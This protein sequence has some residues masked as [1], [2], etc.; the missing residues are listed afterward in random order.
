[1]GMAASQA[2]LL[3][4]TARMH[5][6]EYKAQSIQ[7]AKIQLATQ[8]DEVY[9]NY[10]AAL[11]A[12]T[13][14]IKDW[15]GNLIPATFNNICGENAVDIATGNKYAFRDSR[16]ALI[17]DGQIKDGY[18]RFKASGKDCIKG[19]NAAYMFAFYMMG[20]DVTDSSIF[21]TVKDS[22]KSVS[23]K[24]NDKTNQEAIDNIMKSARNAYVAKYGDLPSTTYENAYGPE[25]ILNAYRE[26]YVTV[27][28]V[29]GKIT[30]IKDQEMYELMEGYRKQLQDLLKPSLNTVYKAH[31]DEI[32]NGVKN[33][34]IG[35]QDFN[36]SKFDYYVRMYKE[37]EAAGGNCTSIQDYDS[38]IA[39]YQENGTRAAND[40]D[41]LQNMIKCGKITV[42]MV[43][44]DSKT[45]E[46]S[47]AS[48]S[49]PSDS[50]LEYTTTTTID[51]SAMAKAEAEYEHKNKEI[52]N[53][54]KR[55]DM[56]LSKLETERSALKT[57]YDS[58]KKIIDD[59][60]EKT[61]GIFS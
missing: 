32:Y 18:E 39:D 10:L 40:S 49:V 12:S 50:V 23:D 42:D 20:I 8:Q 3:T 17:V 29:T 56:D 54:D 36:Q 55:F 33:R 30:G 13:L 2:R 60:I 11:D 45:G 5:D 51:K 27:D 52:N 47:F 35:A 9:Q 21:G 43:K 7:E 4:I 22:Q 28:S 46:V 48:T 61:F 1:M 6:I 14:T 53:K 58:I 19:A 31:A 41:W 44:V 59:N 25:D 24:Y 34:L 37:I 15:E 38:S 26:K 16:G 57:Q